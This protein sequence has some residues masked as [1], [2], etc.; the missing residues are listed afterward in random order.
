MLGKWALGPSW[1]GLMGDSVYMSQ[2]KVRRVCTSEL[3]RVLDQ[4]TNFFELK[5]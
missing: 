4:S 2:T 3:L 5:T 1:R